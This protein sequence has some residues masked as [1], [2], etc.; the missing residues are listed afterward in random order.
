MFQY[1][2][3]FVLNEFKLPSFLME[4][5]CLHLNDNLY[6]NDKESQSHLVHIL[7]RP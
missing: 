6:R 5:D 2:A 7:L 3:V 1:T 4:C